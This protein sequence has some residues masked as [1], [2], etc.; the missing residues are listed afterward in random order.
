M[1]ENVMANISKSRTGVVVGA[2][3]GLGHVMWSVL[4][5]FGVAQWVINW[6]FRLHFIQPPYTITAFNFGTAVT[7]IVVT[8]VIGFVMGWLFA[9]IWNVLHSHE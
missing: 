4:V 2:L 9:A 7:L 8:S 1:G 5:A 3:I 6:I